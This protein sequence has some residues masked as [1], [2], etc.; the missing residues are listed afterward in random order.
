MLRFTIS[1]H[2]TGVGLGRTQ[3]DH[4]DWFFQVSPDP[5]APLL[6]LACDTTGNFLA[7]SFQRLAD[8]R[9]IYLDY[10]GEVS[11]NRGEMTPWVTGCHQ[12][13]ENRSDCLRVRLLSSGPV[14]IGEDALQGPHT[15]LGREVDLKSGKVLEWNLSENSIWKCR[16]IPCNRP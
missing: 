11:A 6:T 1:L 15:D 2:R 4:L 8:H 10:Q 3:E 14:P 16:L 13:V 5:K 7:S 9:A 12:I